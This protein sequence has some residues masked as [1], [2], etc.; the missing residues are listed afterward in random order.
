MRFVDRKLLEASDVLFGFLQR[1]FK[2]RTK[3]P[4]FDPYL[5][6]FKLKK[7]LQAVLDSACHC[8]LETPNDPANETQGFVIKNLSIGVTRCRSLGGVPHGLAC[9]FKPDIFIFSILLALCTFWL[10]LRLAKFRNS[11]YLAWGVRHAISDFGVLIAV[12]VF[13]LLSK[14]TGLDVPAL[15]FPMKLTPTMDRPWIVDVLN[16]EGYKVALFALLPAFFYSILV[17]MDQQITAGIVNRKDN[18]LKKGDGYHLDLL[19]VAVLILACSVLGLPFYVASTVLSMTHV[20]S[21]KSHSEIAAPGEK[22]RFLGVKFMSHIAF[23]FP[24][25]LVVMVLIRMFILERIFAPL[26]LRSLDD[27]LP[28]FGRVMRPRP[29]APTRSMRNSISRRPTLSKQNLN[30]ESS[31]GKRKKTLTWA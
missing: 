16:I 11:P 10:T 17:V 5:P 18:K 30:G 29:R 7:L 1:L 15:K 6:F 2:R 14:M 25:M 31:E 13:T 26:E 8:L 21:L 20:D 9:F 19:V 27:E 23:V 12:M 24:I 22:A 4:I 3:N 28:D